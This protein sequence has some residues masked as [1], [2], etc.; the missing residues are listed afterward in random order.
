MWPYSSHVKEREKKN[1]VI[2]IDDKQK[3][4]KYSR[5]RIRLRTTRIMLSFAAGPPLFTEYR[6]GFYGR[7][8]PRVNQS[9][10]DHDVEHGADIEGIQASGFNQP[11]PFPAT[12]R[13][14]G[15][16]RDQG[17]ELVSVV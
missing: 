12:G 5:C 15:G 9:I 3:K 16:E 6:R 10:R 14:S 1:K 13:R 7:S 8:G 4:E 11:N 17:D 2:K